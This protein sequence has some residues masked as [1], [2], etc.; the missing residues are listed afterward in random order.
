MSKQ[1][2]ILYVG[3]LWEGSTCLER[4]R[5][6]A[7]MG[8]QIIPFDT[9]PWITAGSRWQR[10]IGS[11]FHVGCSVSGLNAA[12]KQFS[13]RQS[14]LTH[15]WI[16]KGQWIY[17]DTLREIKQSTSATLIHYT[18][19]P[20]LMLHQSRHFRSCIPEYDLLATTKPFEVELYKAHGAKQVILILQ[21]YD[22]R[23]AP[24]VPRPDEKAQLGSDSCFIGHYESHYDRR[25]YAARSVGAHLRVW[26]PRWKRYQWLHPW[27]WSH[28]VGDG[29]WGKRYPLA[30]ASTKIALGLLSKRIP[31]TTTTRTFEIPAMGVFMLAERTAD[32]LALFS[33]G[34]EAE[35]F[36]SDE[37]LRDKLRFY[38]DHES[39][40]VR[41]A[42]GG[43]E[44][45][46]KSEYHVRTQLRRVLQKAA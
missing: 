41:I 8:C 13:R 31:E 24:L 16:D 25:L 1:S 9:M 43:R 21:G 18:P 10:S 27:A 26:G 45:C 4:M 42:A 28:V 46:L 32:H 33:E 34:L 15:V 37:E 7:S 36:D 23:F 5:T 38:L 30:L 39:S 44:R 14:S 6:L 3:M 19:D 22:D 40:R 2:T 11:R 17:P 20:Q 29:I 12:L 35:F